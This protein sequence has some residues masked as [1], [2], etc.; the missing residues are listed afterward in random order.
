MDLAP[1]HKDKDS[2]S[3]VSPHLPPLQASLYSI[4][5]CRWDVEYFGGTS[6]RKD[7]L[8]FPPS[9]SCLT[10]FFPVLPFSWL[11]RQDG[12]LE[13]VHPPSWSLPT[14]CH[15]N[16]FSVRHH[17]SPLISSQVAV[18][19]K[20]LVT[21]WWSPLFPVHWTSIQLCMFAICSST[22]LNHIYL[23]FLL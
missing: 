23:W 3:S 9:P 5:I 21:W 1:Q 17:V 20:L 16:A 6:P 22:F 8:F 15:L 10:P 14:S 18:W 7:L 4:L 19:W 2:L 11:F 12:C 13:D